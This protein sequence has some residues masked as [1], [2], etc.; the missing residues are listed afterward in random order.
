[1]DITKHYRDIIETINDFANK[2]HVSLTI[3]KGG[4]HRFHTDEQ[5]AFLDNWIKGMKTELVAIATFCTFASSN[6]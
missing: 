3:M 2:H 5:M 1:V 4:E 6:S